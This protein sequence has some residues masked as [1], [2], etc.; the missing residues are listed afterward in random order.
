MNRNIS[1]AAAVIAAVALSGCAGIPLSSTRFSGSS[2]L[3]PESVQSGTVIKT[4]PI[5][6]NN[7]ARVDQATGLGAGAGGIAGGIGGA[8]A[9]S[10]II[11]ALIGAVGGGVIGDAITPGS[12][13]GTDVF[14][15]LATG[16]TLS[17]PESGVIH[18]TPGEKV[19]IIT[20]AHGHYRVE[21]A[22]QPPVAKVKPVVNRH[23]TGPHGTKE[24]KE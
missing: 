4:M 8:M 17:I 2:N 10:P 16:Q 19:F 9:G 13:V 18:L 5:K 14:V 20:S 24:I 22:N 12:G 21:P 23:E 6:I 7:S 11:G 3:A 15:R 1:V